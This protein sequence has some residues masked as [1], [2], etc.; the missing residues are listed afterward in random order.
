MIRIVRLRFPDRVCLLL[1]WTLLILCRALRLALLF[2][3]RDLNRRWFDRRL[4][5]KMGLPYLSL[6]LYRESLC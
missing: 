1:P 5:V 3:A 2:C 4:V 6:S